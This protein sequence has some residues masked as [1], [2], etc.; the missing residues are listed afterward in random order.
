MHLEMERI[1]GP[2]G[3]EMAKLGLIFVLCKFCVEKPSFV[4]CKEQRV[5]IKLV[6]NEYILKSFPGSSG[7]YSNEAN[8]F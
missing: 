6:L 1:L 3:K 2:N 7:L 4:M 8:V 5:L